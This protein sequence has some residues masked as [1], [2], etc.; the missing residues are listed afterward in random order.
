ML[1]RVSDSQFGRVRL[2]TGPESLLAD[3]AVADA[4]DAARAERSDASVTT[5]EAAQLDAGTLA[6]VTG[7]SLFA[8][9]AIVVIMNLAELPATL[10]DPVVALAERP[11]PDLALVLVHAGGVKG[12]ALLDRVR[13]ARAV[14]VECP[15]VKP[16]ELPQFA[17]AEARRLGGRMDAATAGV[18][19]ESVGTDLRTVAAAVRQLLADAEEA[20]I[21]EAVVRRY[22][23]GRAD[24]TSFG[25]AD[26]A[27]AGRP[28]QALGKLRWALA[29][30]VPPVLVT[31]ALS[32]GL[33]N[34]GR[35]LDARDA[36]VRDADL[37]RSIGVPPWK[38][39]DLARQ[40]RE[41][42]PAGI[43]RAI[44]AVA[45]ADAQIKGAA[46]DPGFALERMVLTVTG[47][48]RRPVDR[49]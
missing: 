8:A 22:F 14:V 42:Q 38:L 15:T 12:K 19:V 35:Y 47:C 27:M 11:L 3:R 17:A 43:A 25:V 24:V 37:A 16:W 32:A 45:V 29:T 44:Q 39:K 30:G 13:K 41:W 49:R 31:S 33:R 9:S 48:R 20:V 6:E 5:V 4:V 23:G 40:A 28:D 34:L 2:V 7:G 26:D 36:R 46:S 1:G 18:L 10:A 21:T